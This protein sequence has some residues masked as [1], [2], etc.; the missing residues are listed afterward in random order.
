MFTSC[1][2]VQYQFFNNEN[3]VFIHY[4]AVQYDSPAIP[5]IRIQTKVKNNIHQNN[6]ISKRTKTQKTFLVTHSP[7][8]RKT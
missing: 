3:F 7:I 2:I 5:A 1:I 6:L 4:E 8:H